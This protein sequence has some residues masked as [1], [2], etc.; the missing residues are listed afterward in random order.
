MKQFSDVL[1]CS[2]K[3]YFCFWGAKCVAYRN[4]AE[5]LEAIKGVYSTGDLLA[6]K[7]SRKSPALKI[8]VT[9]KGLSK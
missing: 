8:F 4:G 5:G 1:H 3:L 9:V 2:N 6:D 7:A